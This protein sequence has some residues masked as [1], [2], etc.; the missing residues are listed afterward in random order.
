MPS[1]FTYT[2]Y[3]AFLRDWCAERRRSSRAFSFRNFARMAGLSSYSLLPMVMAGKR[4][5]TEETIPKVAKA[6]K[7]ENNERRFF[8][9][10]VH[11]NQ[12]STAHEKTHYYRRL[13]RHAKFRSAHPLARQQFEYLSKWHY[14]AIRELM[15]LPRFQED[16]AWIARRFQGAINERDAAQA[17]Q[18][19]LRLGLC[20]RDARGRLRPVNDHLTTANEV[21]SLAAVQYHHAMIGRAAEALKNDHGNERHISAITAPMSRVTFQRIRK[22]LQEVRDEIYTILIEDR[23][24]ADIYQFNLQLFRLTKE[25]V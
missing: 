7:L 13:L 23:S 22:R 4:S 17:I 3:R 20:K 10:L 2:D 24:P 16:P 1:L 6:L 12:G 9:D 25:A 5:L 15:A 8:A 14:A 19:L 21:A 18:V 11:F